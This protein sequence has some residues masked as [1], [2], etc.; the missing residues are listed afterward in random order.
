[1]QLYKV[2]TTNVCLSQGSDFGK[3]QRRDTFQTYCRG[4]KIHRTLWSTWIRLR[5]KKELRMISTWLDSCVRLW[6]GCPAGGALGVSGENNEFSLTHA[7][8]A[9]L[10]NNQTEVPA[11]VGY[12]NNN[13]LLGARSHSIESYI[14]KLGFL[15]LSSIDI[16]GQITHH[17]GCP[18]YCSL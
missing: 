12:N 9:V 14:C 8:F 11:G 6:E 16:W 10:L 13:D 17:G 7:E 2:K 4:G 1:M 15:S 18:V 5:E 3:W